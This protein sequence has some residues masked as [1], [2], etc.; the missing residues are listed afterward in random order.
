MWI[1]DF[2]FCQDKSSLRLARG[3]PRSRGRSQW[4]KRSR[5]G[6]WKSFISVNHPGV[7]R[8][9]VMSTYPHVVATPRWPRIFFWARS[10]LLDLEVDE[11][12]LLPCLCSSFARSS[13]FFSM[14]M[15]RINQNSHA[16]I[17][18]LLPKSLSKWPTS[19]GHVVVTEMAPTAGTEVGMF[20][21]IFRKSSPILAWHLKYAQGHSQGL[22]LQV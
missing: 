1:G 4:P 8:G 18:Y 6:G 9:V 10:F 11:N 20:S 12:Q 17:N 13:A 16:G 19:Y 5:R 7:N 21:A 2:L 3:D 15:R 14:R 22:S